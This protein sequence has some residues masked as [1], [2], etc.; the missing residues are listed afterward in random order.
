MVHAPS[1][2]GR[3]LCIDRRSTRPPSSSGL[4]PRTH[5]GPSKAPAVRTASASSTLIGETKKAS[6]HGK[7]LSI[8]SKRNA[9]AGQTGTRVMKFVWR[10]RWKSLWIRSRST[11]MIFALRLPFMT[12][13]RAVSFQRF[14]ETD[15]VTDHAIVEDIVAA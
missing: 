4:D 5:A 2:G 6:G 3:I 10:Y 8:T 14:H 9:G 13:F 15:R 12:G 11:G 7:R 1:S